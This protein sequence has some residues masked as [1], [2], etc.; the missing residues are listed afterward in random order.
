MGRPVTVVGTML[1]LVLV[2]ASAAGEQR[3]TFT[4]PAPPKVNDLPPVDPAVAKS[5]PD[6]TFHAAPKPLPAG[7]VTHDWP[8]FLGPTH[9]LHSTETKLVQTLAAGGPPRV[10]EMK[11]GSGYAAPAVLGERLVLFHRVGDEE[12]VECLNALSG[13]RFWAFA[14]PTAYQDRYGYS[15]GPRASPVI[16]PDGQ[17]VVT[18]GAEGTLHCLELASGRVKW[19]RKIAPDFAILQDFFGV[20]ST[21]LVEGD[22]LIVNVGKPGGPCVAAFEVKT[23]RMVWGAGDAWGPSYASPIPATVLGRRRVF[24]FAGGESD[25]PTGGLL[26]IDP[27]D[28]S[29]DFTFPWRGR[30]RESVNASS[31]LIFEG[32]R[33]LVSEAYGAG[34]A[35]LELTEDPDKRLA[36]KPLWT[37][38]SFGTHFMTAVYKDGHLYGVDG[39]GPNDAFLVCVDAATGKEIWR[40]QPEWAEVVQS[41]TGPRKMRMG[42]YRAWIMP[43]DGRFLLTGEFGHLLFADLSPKGCTVSSRSQLFLASETWTPPVLSHGLLYICQN[44][45]STIDGSPARLLCYDFRAAP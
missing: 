31:P 3:K 37:S 7:A 13:Q 33:V 19:T 35:V 30:R 42:T 29:V 12:R 26:C 27:A 17:F 34:G 32:N 14:Y 22:K 18:Y 2:A 9:D 25:P 44:T 36:C 21:P 15:D 23:G 10:W 16:T 41:R 28:G 8:S 4:D 6:V 45:A 11:K 40:T 5:N 39:H 1:L 20:G 24:V 38:E 43:V